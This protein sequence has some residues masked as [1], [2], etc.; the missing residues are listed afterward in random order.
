MPIIHLF[1][2]LRRIEQLQSSLSRDRSQRSSSSKGTPDVPR[3]ASNSSASSAQTTAALGDADCSTDQST[4]SLGAKIGAL[5][6]RLLGGGDEPDATASSAS[7]TA[8]AASSGV[9]TK[10]TA[11]AKV[12]AAL[13]SMQA[14]P[15]SPDCMIK[16]NISSGGRERIYHMPGGAAYEKTQID[17]AA[18]ERW[19]CN[20]ADAQAAGWRRAKS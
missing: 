4:T 16:G 20:E 7:E 2:L 3:A 8:G 13:G 6:R 19:F 9:K 5:C 11:G 1:V 18:G 17:V 15:P 12:V 10:A 14:G